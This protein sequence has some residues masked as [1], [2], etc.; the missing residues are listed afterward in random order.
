M[1]FA[2]CDRQQSLSLLCMSNQSWYP[3]QPHHCCS[4]PF[5]MEQGLLGSSGWTLGDALL[6]KHNGNSALW[7]SSWIW[8][9]LLWQKGPWMEWRSVALKHWQVNNCCF[10]MSC[11][12]VWP[13]CTL[14]GMAHLYTVIVQYGMAHLYTVSD[15]LVMFGSASSFAG[16][17]L[18]VES[19]LIDSDFSSYPL[20]EIA[21]P[22]VLKCSLP[23]SLHLFKNPWLTHIKHLKV[24][25]DPSLS[26]P[27]WP[28]SGY[29]EILRLLWALRDNSSVGSDSSLSASETAWTKVSLFRRFVGSS[30]IPDATDAGSV[31]TTSKKTVVTS[32]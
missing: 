15:C 22:R 14:Y 2:A 24:E 9:S 5:W 18:A 8:R 26:L 20:K 25:V 3:Q 32:F 7:R 4:P 19:R 6:M 30:R 16:K 1:K 13:I 28:M 17:F 27:Q 10:F 23:P 11:S 29:R 12:M 31:I 21:F